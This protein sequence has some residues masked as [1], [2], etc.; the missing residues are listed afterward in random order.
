MRGYL[1]FIIIGLLVASLVLA[2]AFTPEQKTAISAC[3]LDCKETKKAAF[4]GCVADQ[5]ICKD[6]CV[7]TYD[8]CV[9]TAEDTRQ[10]CLQDCASQNLT[11]GSFSSCTRQ[12][13]G[14]FREYKRNECDLSGCRSICNREAVLCKKTVRADYRWCGIACVGNTL[15]PNATCGAYR[16]GDQFVEDC[17][18]CECNF[19]GTTSCRPSINCFYSNFTITETSCLNA[20]GLFQP[21]C[22]GP[23]FRLRCTLEDYCICD[24]LGQYACPSDT[25]CLHNFT[26]RVK[27]DLQGYRGLQGEEIGD[28]GICAQQPELE[29]CGNGVCD[30]LLIKD[31]TSGENQFNCPTDCV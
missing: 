9:A 7:Q 28:I 29:H 3:K 19:D 14:S 8:T 20:G 26:V 6:A 17:K 23:Y 13:E 30:A 16:P 4:L 2:A 31:G 5:D 24:G 10:I 22:K 11:S 15:Y 25:F 1:I 18:E 12:C 27:S 21:V